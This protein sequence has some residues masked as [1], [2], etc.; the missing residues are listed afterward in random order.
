MGDKNYSK[1]QCRK[2]KPGKK[3]KEL[4]N[5]YTNHIQIYSSMLP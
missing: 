3:E 5:Q 2:K 4:F 1:Q